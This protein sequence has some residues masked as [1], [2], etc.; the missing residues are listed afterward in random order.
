[1]TITEMKTRFASA[2]AAAFV[3]AAGLTLPPALARQEGW[4]AERY[5]QPGKDLNAV[6]FIDSKRGWVAG[7]GGL[8]LRTDDAGRSWTRQNIEA[9]GSINDIYF[10]DKQDGYLLA[11]HQIF[12]TE[13]GGATWRVVGRFP[14][15]DFSGAEPELY[16][17]R[18][19]SKK[20]GWVVGSLSRR[21]SVVDS[22]VF[23]TADGGTS[24]NRQRVPAAE[25]LIHLDF[26]GDKR[27][28]IVG[29]GGAILHT[30]DAGETWTRQESKTKATL[31]HVDFENSKHGWAVGEHGAILRT[32]D[33]GETWTVVDA[34]VRSTL[35]SVKFASEADG[36]IVGRGGVILRSGDGGQTWV[37]Q[38]SHTKQN[39]YALYFDKKLGWAVGGDGTVL[40]YER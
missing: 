40:R 13:D 24:W 35:L 11:G 3:L 16:S 25:E 2:T 26:D 4:R 29:A 39:I 38:E 19:T 12:V 6:H 20:K 36:W 14:A 17:V 37:K 5:G 27:G 9:K 22:L 30:R 8:V 34:P 21:D 1:M 23:Y 31:Y 28:W 32:D 7:D 33:G 15:S 18:F 10:R